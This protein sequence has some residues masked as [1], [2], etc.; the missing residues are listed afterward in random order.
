[1]IIILLILLF[2]ESFTAPSTEPIR[3]LPLN[4]KYDKRKAQLG[5]LLFHDPIL[6]KDRSVSCASCHDVYEKCGT[7]H[8]RFSIGVGGR[9][10]SAN[11]P[12]VLNAVFNFRQF[13]NGR[14]RDLKEQVA[15]PIQNPVEMNL[16]P[17][18]VEGRLNA[19]ESYR[20]LFKEIYGTDRISFEQVVDAIAEFEKALITPNSKFDK[21]LRGETELSK[22]EEE[23]YKLFKRLGC[24]TC[25]N[26]VNV[27]GNSFQLFG[28]VIPVEWKPTNPDRYRITKRE[29]DKNRYK[30]PTLRNIA[31]TQPYF[32]DGSARTLEE[33]V[34]KMAYHNLGLKLKEEEIRKIVLFLKTLTGEKPEILK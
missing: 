10:G 22:E 18:E 21:Y 27:G 1:M 30:V 16:T 26:G 33:A 8:R 9:L 13:W 29:F 12:T 3:P 14:A 7:D 4:I 11:S 19:S 32:H 20:K 6:S 28:A 2:I 17:G 5:K 25:H 24:I 34:E 31:C 23:G 15:F